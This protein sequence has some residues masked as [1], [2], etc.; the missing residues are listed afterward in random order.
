MLGYCSHV[1]GFKGS[2]RNFKA[3][4]RP[5][6]AFIAWRVRTAGNSPIGHWAPPGVLPCSACSLRLQHTFCLRM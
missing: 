4:A 1:P 6:L 3:V 2:N 5:Q